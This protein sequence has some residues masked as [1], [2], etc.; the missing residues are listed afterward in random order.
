MR[1]SPCR[2]W[3]RASKS[4][5]CHAFAAYVYLSQDSGQAWGRESMPPLEHH[6]VYV[7]SDEKTLRLI[8]RRAQV[9]DRGFEPLTAIPE[10]PIRHELA[11]NEPETLAQSLAREKE[12]P[13]PVR[14]VL[15]NWKDL[16]EPARQA[17]L[18]AAQ[19]ALAI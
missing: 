12:L 10:G 18:S 7:L 11:A 1:F 5:G 16:P 19:L 13:E 9:E 3:S 6:V 17:L 4:R 8:G 2:S 14:R 15:S